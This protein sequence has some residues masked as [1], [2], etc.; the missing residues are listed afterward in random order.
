MKTSLKTHW[1]LENLSFN[2]FLFLSSF[3]FFSVFLYLCLVV[4]CM[5][6]LLNSVSFL[7]CTILFLPSILP[8]SQFLFCIAFSLILFV[9][10]SVTNLLLHTTSHKTVWPCTVTSNSHKYLL[11]THKNTQQLTQTMSNP[12]TRN[13]PK[14]VFPQLPFP[15]H[16]PTTLGTVSIRRSADHPP[17]TDE[18]NQ[19]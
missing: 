16:N 13:S 2:F 9:F 8:F 7:T 14:P 19:R 3:F 12:C 11:S 6:I 4:L 5:S 17:L 18:W 1:Y 15:Q 10:V